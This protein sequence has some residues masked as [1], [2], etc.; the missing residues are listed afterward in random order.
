MWEKLLSHIRNRYSNPLMI[1]SVDGHG[2][3]YQF[4]NDLAEALI[5]PWWLKFKTLFS[6]SLDK[7]NLEDNIC[8]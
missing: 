3:L 1:G 7:S 6:S 2:R 8:T 5:W 4:M